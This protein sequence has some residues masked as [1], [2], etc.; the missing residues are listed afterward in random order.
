M[1]DH[2][3]MKEAS[4]QI[5]NSGKFPFTGE[6]PAVVEKLKFVAQAFVQLQGKR[7]IADYDNS[8]VWSPAEAG[9]EFLTAA[10][11]FDR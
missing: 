11:A 2:K 4:K 8:R 9:A 7:H 1:F 10:R 3:V 6:D 5:S